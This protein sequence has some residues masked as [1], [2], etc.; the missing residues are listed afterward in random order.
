MIPTTIFVR[1]ARRLLPSLALGFALDEF[2]AVIEPGTF[3]WR[4]RRLYI[5]VLGE[6][7]FWKRFALFAN[8]RNLRDQPEDREIAGPSTPEHAQFRQRVD[9]GSLWTFG[10]K[11]TF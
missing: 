6:Y 5:D 3:E 1:S 11:G 4:G 7:Y 10:I 9:F 8:L 2:G